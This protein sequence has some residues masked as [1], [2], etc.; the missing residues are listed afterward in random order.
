MKRKKKSVPPAE[1]EAAPFLL[2]LARL[3]AQH[4]VRDAARILTDAAPYMPLWR[5]GLR[6]SP[7]RASYDA[8]EASGRAPGRAFQ[9]LGRAAMKILEF[10]FNA[11]G[12]RYEL[13]E[14]QGLVCMVKQT[15]IGM[16][17]WCY[18]VVKLRIEPDKIRFGNLVPAHE[19][20]PSDEDWGTYGFTYRPGEFAKARQRFSRMA[21]ALALEPKTSHQNQEPVQIVS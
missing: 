12:F 2:E 9:P 20:Y 5:P 15:R 7:S 10:P 11:R 13:I 4:H 14:H 19:R 6:F 18:E 21:N 3:R 1:P 8:R 17:Y 16:S